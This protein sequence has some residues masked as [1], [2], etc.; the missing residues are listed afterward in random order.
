LLHVK[1]LGKQT[2]GG[3]EADGKMYTFQPP[4]APAAPGAKGLPGFKGPKLGALPKAP[5][6]PKPP[7]PGLAPPGVAM[8]AA[9]QPPAPGAP[10]GKV[11]TLEVWTHTKL[12]VPVLTKAT[13]MPGLQ[14]SVCKD[15]KGGEPPAS[16]FQIPPG[17][18]LIQ[19]KPPALPPRG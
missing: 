15:A 12:K 13:G 16:L 7:M 5:G 4:K 3:H 19:P 1:D 9:G 18:K 8:P 17:Y 2:I 6:L 10:Q 14:S 11:Q